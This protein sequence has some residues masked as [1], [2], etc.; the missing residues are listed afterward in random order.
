MLQALQYVYQALQLLY[1]SLQHKFQGLQHKIS[2]GGEYFLLAC[3]YKQTLL[4][5]IDK[6]P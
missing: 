4:A 2:L 1:Q 6:K 5:N 3:E